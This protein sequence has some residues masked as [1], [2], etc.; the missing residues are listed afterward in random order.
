MELDFWE[1]RYIQKNTPWDIGQPSPAFVEYFSNNKTN[2]SKIAVLGC[3]RGHDAFFLSENKNL[4]IYGFDFSKS[5]MDFCNQLKEENKIN[6]IH[7]YEVDIFDLVRDKKWSE[8]FDCV[9]EHTTLCAIKPRLRSNYVSLV[10]YL[11]KPEGK[12]VGMF[13]IRPLELGG[14]PFGSTVD[15][16]REL[17]SKDFTEIE[18]LRHKECPHTFTGKEYFGVFE[19]KV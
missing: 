19:K 6:N 13:C 10:N 1:T 12:L 2:K 11:L 16:I 9:I 4:E 17:F 14:P 8:Y 7:F 3:G 18:P 15:E 5:A